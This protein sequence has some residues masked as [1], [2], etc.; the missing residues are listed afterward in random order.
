MDKMDLYNKDAT[1][2]KHSPQVV[3]VGASI[4]GLQ[5]A[6]DLQRA[7]VSCI[8]LEARNRIGG[9]CYDPYTRAD[10]C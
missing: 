6:Y 7:G 8:V 9:N 4:I 5:T 2:S 1:Q 10:T 3:V